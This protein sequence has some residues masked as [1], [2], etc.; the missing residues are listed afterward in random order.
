MDGGDARTGVSP[1][2]DFASHQ[3]VP[4]GKE[5]AS[6]GVPSTEGLGWGSDDEPRRRRP[7]CGALPTLMAFAMAAPAG[8][9]PGRRLR[10]TSPAVQLPSIMCPPGTARS[11]QT[12]QEHSTK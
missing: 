2:A 4:Q 5:N 3:W 9:I 7:L 1:I 12:L 6:T 11:D 8:S 10:R